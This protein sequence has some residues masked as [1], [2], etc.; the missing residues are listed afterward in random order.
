MRG[1]ECDANC[2][3][4]QTV[5]EGLDVR[6]VATSMQVIGISPDPIKGLFVHD[7]AD[8]EIPLQRSRAFL[9]DVAAA[10][11]VIVAWGAPLT[12]PPRSVIEGAEASGDAF[13][14]RPIERYFARSAHGLN[15]PVR[16][17]ALG[18]AHGAVWA[19]SRS[20]VG[21]PRV[22]P[23]DA[24]ASSLPFRLLSRQDMRPASGS[25]IV[26]V[27]ALVA[28]WLWCGDVWATGRSWLFRED[29]RV[30]DELWSGLLDVEAVRDA[31]DSVEAIPPRSDNEL[32]ARVAYALG[33]LWLDEPDRVVLQGDAD[34]GAFLV[35]RVSGS[36]EESGVF[37]R[38]QVPPPSLSGDA[39]V[40]P[41][42]GQRVDAIALQLLEE[43][44]EGVRRGE[45]IDGILTADESL[46]PHTVEYYI[47][48]LD[49]R[50]A[51]SV[52]KPRRGVFQLVE[53][54]DI[55]STSSAPDPR[56][57]PL[58]GAGETP[59]VSDAHVLADHIRSLESKGFVYLAPEPPWG[60]M[61]MTLSA[62]VLQRNMRYET[63]L[64]H[65]RRLRDEHP[66]TAATTSGFAKL[67][68][69]VGLEVLL[70]WKDPAS[71]ATLDDLVRVLRGYRVETEVDLRTWLEDP[72]HRLRIRQIT[73]I[74]NKTSEFIRLRCGAPDAVALD[75]WL[76]QMLD[77]AGVRATGFWGRH[78]VVCDAA[79]LLGVSP[80]TLEESIWSYMRRRP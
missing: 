72:E 64:A 6:E 2:R 7:G 57:L 22:G 37:S 13:F 50:L 76:N 24:Q 42:I 75:R 40:T 36:E 69:E 63:V 34:S 65:A 20:L 38:L 31:L 14:R 28:L 70:D 44:S 17:L 68:G 79:G 43:R 41:T 12:G 8:R 73:G 45:L 66:E 26:E 46:N 29:P 35:P 71:L 23:Y 52:F 16:A 9:A 15:T 30:R 58:R 77:E 4:N 21:L 67:A 48:D 19:L 62:C 25:H 55:A 74:G 80:A 54:S 53:D 39:A 3:A 18:Y 32:Y 27:H 61:G 5:R 59:G 60:H 51:T 47:R 1:S 11:D 33:R 78:R 10:G 49:K 56:Q